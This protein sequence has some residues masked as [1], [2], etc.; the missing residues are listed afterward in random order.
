MKN[1]W[2]FLLFVFFFLVRPPFVSAYVENNTGGEELSITAGKTGNIICTFDVPQ[3]YVRKD[4]GF[5]LPFDIEVT[6]DNKQIIYKM[7]S[8]D[9]QVIL[10]EIKGAYTLTLKIA[11]HIDVCNIQH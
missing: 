1:Q 10:P 9:F 6:R 7:Q 8:N 2:F 4:G 5:S 11:D 3:K